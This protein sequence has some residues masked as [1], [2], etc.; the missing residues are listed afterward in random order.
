MT[1]VKTENFYALNNVLLLKIFETK[2]FHLTNINT[3]NFNALNNVI[4]LKILEP[5]IFHLTNVK[6]NFLHLEQCNFAKNF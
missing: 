3:E 4:L 6:A 5:K 1:N 2:I